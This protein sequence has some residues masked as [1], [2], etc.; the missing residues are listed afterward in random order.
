MATAEAQDPPQRDS[1]SKKTS[2][3]AD[4]STKPFLRLV[5]LFTVALR[6]QL[7]PQGVCL[8]FGLAVVVTL[9]ANI[10]KAAALFLSE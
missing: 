2:T 8:L 6:S 9:E 5:D 4:G 10:G 3:G 1:S 7:A